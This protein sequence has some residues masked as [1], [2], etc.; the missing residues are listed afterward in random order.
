VIVSER[1]VGYFHGSG[2]RLAARLAYPRAARVITNAQPIAEMLTRHHLATPQQIVVIPN[3]VPLPS[4]ADSTEQKV[5]TRRQFGLP[6]DGPIIASV[7]RFAPIKGH[8]TFVSAIPEV[9]ARF[10]QCTF[11]LAGQGEC[12]PEL[13]QQARAL[14]I[15]TRVHFVG[16]VEDVPAFLAGVDVFVMPSLSEGLAN[17]LMEAMGRARPIVA[18]AVGGNCELIEPE[19]TGLLVPPGDA[20]ALA[21]GI[22]ALLSDPARG[23]RLG[24]AAQAK[25]QSYSIA[26]MTQRVTALYDQLLHA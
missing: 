20:R 3:G 13:Q 17:A 19:R 1:N 10:P 6:V 7:G 9:L 5:G 8:Q 23:Q 25:V 12:L 26:A 14:G 24:E 2:H 16:L 15:E 11:A 4:L 21:T 22:C 18:T